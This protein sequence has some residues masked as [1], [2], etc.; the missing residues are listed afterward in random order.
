MH[1]EDTPHSESVGDDNHGRDLDAGYLHLPDACAQSSAE[2]PALEASTRPRG[3]LIAPS[4]TAAAIPAPGRRPTYVNP[5]QYQRIEKRREARAK[6]ESL[7]KVSHER[8]SYLHESRHKHACRRKRGPSG[9]FLTKA[10]LEA[11]ADERRADP[12][13]APP[14]RRASE[15]LAA[16]AMIAVGQARVDLDDRGEKKARLG[17]PTRDCR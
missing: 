13:S 8:K 15:D 10:E 9:R 16:T 5:K 14:M 7:W 3:A 4:S 17:L 6:L 1:G 12:A 11:H 2:T